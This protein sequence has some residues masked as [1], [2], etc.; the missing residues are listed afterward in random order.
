VSI[1]ARY[2]AE[3]HPKRPRPEPSADDRDTM[4][5]N[6]QNLVLARHNDENF[7]IPNSNFGQLVKGGGSMV[8]SIQT[9]RQIR[10]GA[11]FQW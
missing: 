3:A 1:R 8:T 5:C 2:L 4:C 10:L 9:L 7:G 11:R 6:P